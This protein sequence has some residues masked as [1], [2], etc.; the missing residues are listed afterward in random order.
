MDNFVYNC[1]CDSVCHI[2]TGISLDCLK[3]EQLKIRF[4]INALQ[5][6][7][8]KNP[9]DIDVYKPY[10]RLP[11]FC[12]QVGQL[13]TIKMVANAIFVLSAHGF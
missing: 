5:T 10:K 7:P 9:W 12:A 3:I 1:L 8:G 11:H 13:I 6:L 4:K 2:K